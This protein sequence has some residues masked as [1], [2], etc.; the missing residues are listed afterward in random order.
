MHLLQNFWGT[1]SNISYFPKNFLLA[2]EVLGKNLFASGVTAQSA[3]RVHPASLHSS[4]QCASSDTV[5]LVC[6]MHPASLH[7]SIQC[8]SMDTVES[9]CR[10]NPASMLSSMQCGSRVS[11]ELGCIQCQYLVIVQGAFIVTA[12]HAVCWLNPASL[13]SQH[14]GCIMLHF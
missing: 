11:D 2:Q 14:A 8:A 7:S 12:V 1:F 4:I 13:S 9:A 3:S 5:E 10:E 6:R